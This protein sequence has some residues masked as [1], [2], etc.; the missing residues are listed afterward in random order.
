MV[1]AAAWW[2]RE[3]HVVLSGIE[4]RSGSLFRNQAVFNR[5]IQSR[6]TP[7]S[8]QRFVEQQALVRSAL[9]VAVA[10]A[11]FSDTTPVAELLLQ[12]REHVQ[13]V[14]APMSRDQKV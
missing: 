6:A 2:G 12:A 11:V 13:D 10:V 5:V 4:E 1:P 3:E 9:A 8:T 14:A 7:Y